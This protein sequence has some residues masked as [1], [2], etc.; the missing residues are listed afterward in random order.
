MNFQVVKTFVKMVEIENENCIYIRYIKAFHATC[1]FLFP[2]KTL[3][4]QR[5][6]N[7]FR[8]HR[9]KQVEWVE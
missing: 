1:L 2:L 5:F 3:E 9:M 8:G 4:K 6:S 7:V